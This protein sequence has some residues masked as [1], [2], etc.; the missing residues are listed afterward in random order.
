MKKHYD[1]VV[2][3][4]G[5]AGLTS[6]VGFKN[7]GKSVLLIEKEHMGGECTN[8]GC[9][10]SKSLLYH[11]KNYYKSHS[12]S[13]GTEQLETYRQNVLSFV[14]KKIQ[15]ILDHE[16]PEVFQE[17][18]I[19]V[20]MGEAEFLSPD[21]L[22]VQEDTYTF[23]KAV[24]A[25]GSS[26]R[27]IEISGLEE[28]D[29]LTNQ[30]VFSQ[31]KLPEKLLVIGS[32]PIGMELGQAFAM[33]GTHVSI[34]T[35]DSTFGSRMEPEVALILQKESEKLGIEILTNAH[36]KSVSG[37]TATIEIR[38]D[39]EE[40]LKTIT[41]EFDK[42]IVAIGR[43]PNLPQGLT[44]AGVSYTDHG[45]DIDRH[46]RTTNKNI[47]A[48]GDVSLRN[49]FTHT[50]DD[51]AR[52]IVKKSLIP[53]TLPKT[54]LV[55]KVTFTKPEAASVGLSWKQAV[56]EYSESSLVRLSVPFSKNDRALTDEATE[57]GHI[58]VIAK[59]LTG[60]IVGAH[61]V[62]Q[63]A[64]E[65]LSF[66]TLAM[67]RRISLW[68]INNL[69]FPYP[70]ISLIIKKVSDEFLAY[71]LRNIKPDIYAVL[72]RN[73]KKIFAL[74]FW[75]LLIA[76]FFWYKNTNDLSFL[77]IATKLGD[78][79]MTVWGPLIFILIYTFRPLIF[80]PATLLTILAGVL[81]GLWGG[82]LY[83]MIG[84]NLSANV[85]Y[86]VGRFFG[87]DVKLPNGI[88][89]HFRSEVQRNSFM[90]VL[91]AR[92]IY[93][94]FDLTNYASGILKV[95]WSSY[96]LATIIGI[97]PGMATFVALGASF[98]SITE[99]DPSMVSIDTNTLLLSTVLFISSL[100][101]AK[102]LQKR[103]KQS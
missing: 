100:G 72:K 73:L 79:N 30:N 8:T 86:A 28:Q 62:G 92:F 40:V 31:E 25:T 95:K 68:K 80:F 15:D 48:V 1:V 33:L 4:A 22:K 23:S 47:F 94:P 36:V 70:T 89:K 53:F 63:S 5:S 32:G 21:S 45:V 90:S 12:L 75:V 64:G 56:E 19:D 3:G 41:K 69:I 98:Q 44:E 46:Y 67:S 24:I 54:K 6:A 77:D 71:Q 35:I 20:I 37:N 38:K 10:P 51:V 83:T 101:L 42:V 81:F 97:I 88:I 49:K 96:A 43:V 85:A 2:I 82:I 84:E 60:Q 26:P 39:S 11:A 14:Q 66:F 87:G 103:Q 61:I 91:I 102:W 78:M 55:P 65:I 93:M 59:K 52:H 58:V 74:F 99:F 9:I 27:M 13:G 18:G 16:T 34:A 7:I 76:G 17:M 50:A 57:S 29:I